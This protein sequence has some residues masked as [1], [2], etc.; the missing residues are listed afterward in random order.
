MNKI[1]SDLSSFKLKEEEYD[2]ISFFKSTEGYKFLI[3]KFDG[4]P[5]LEK[6]DLGYKYYMF[7]ID[8]R[9][10]NIPVVEEAILGDPLH[11]I[12]NYVKANCEGIFAKKSEISKQMLEKFVFGKDSTQRFEDLREF[13]RNEGKEV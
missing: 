12:K 9:D 8:H 5:V 4:N 7:H 2:A 3:V 6:T 13:I 1:I 11:V 10:G